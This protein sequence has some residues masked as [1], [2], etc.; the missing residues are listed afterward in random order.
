MHI[1]LDLFEKICIALVLGGAIGIERELRTKS[2]G[3][4][5]M[6]LICIGSTIFTTFSQVLGVDISP[7]RIASNI[8]VGV[9]FLG[10]G[11]IFKADD[12]VH[13]ITTAATI[14]IAAALGMIVGAGFYGMATV[15]CLMVLIILFVFSFFDQRIDRFN[16]MRNYKIV[17]PY[18]M[19]GQHKYEHCLKQYKLAIKAQSQSK[20]G[21]IITG[22]WL[23]QGNEKNHHKFIEHILKDSSVTEFDF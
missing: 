4:R 19:D 10:A 1:P 5:T 21:N 13:G 2:A 23:V 20:V 16:Q 11:V 12:K 6:M 8:V 17:Y 22:T 3:F 15:A 18:E 7:D 9:G 14:W